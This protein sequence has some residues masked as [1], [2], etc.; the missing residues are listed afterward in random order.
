[1]EEILGGRGRSKNDFQ[2][3][4]IIYYKLL[5]AKVIDVKTPHI[6]LR[7]FHVLL[8]LSLREDL[9]N[10]IYQGNQ[11]RNISPRGTYS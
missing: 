9:S 7:F 3:L 5:F 1:M 8:E 11:Y 10:S 4:K 6:F 2:F